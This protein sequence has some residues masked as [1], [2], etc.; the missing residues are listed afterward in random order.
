MGE[1]ASTTTAA[2][3]APPSPSVI[4]DAPPSPS[5]P[6][7]TGDAPPSPPA[8]PALRKA[9][10]QDIQRLASVL[11]E[12]F[13]DDPVFGWLMPEDSKRHARLRRYFGIELRHYTLPRGH[14][15][16]TDDLA[17]VA[18]NLPPGAWRAP[19]HVTLLEGRP[20]GIHL[21]RAARIG[22]AM[23]WN[24]M[25]RLREPHY[26]V[27][28]IGVQPQM[29]GR[30]LGSTLMGPTLEQCDREGLPAYI[31]ASSVRSAALYERLGFEHIGELHV[32][33]SPPL[34][35]MLRPAAQP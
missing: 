18:M 31:E 10:A 23:E 11:A 33:T 8:A 22:A 12:A 13:F 29:Q 32:G 1:S 5:V 35:L 14:V 24:H 30:G 16:T 21:P 7:V 26:Y 25:R 28:D 34:W 20:F 6:S 17:G 3:D 15:W 27:R 19:T 4:S 9:T 2:G